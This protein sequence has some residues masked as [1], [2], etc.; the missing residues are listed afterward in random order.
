MDYNTLFQILET[1]NIEYMPL[2]NGA[3]GRINYDAYKIIINPIYNDDAKTLLHECL[4]YYYDNIL[5]IGDSVTEYEV[6]CKTQ[7]MTFKDSNLEYILWCYLED[8]K[9]ALDIAK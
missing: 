8:R 3:Y 2:D 4:H 9:Q 7:D 6:E 5:N 1:F